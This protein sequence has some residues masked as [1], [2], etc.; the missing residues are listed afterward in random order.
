[1]KKEYNYN[2]HT[3]TYRCG[4][5]AFELEEEYINKYIE[6]GFKIVGFSDHMP[7]PLEEFPQEN[8]RMYIKDSSKYISKLSKLKNHYKDIEILISFECEYDKLY[9]KH[10]IKLKENSDYLILGQ[11]FIKN[12]NP[13]GNVDYPM[14]Y[15]NRVCEALDTGLFSYIAHPDLYLKYRDSIEISDYDKYINNCKKAAEIICKKA[16]KLNIP[17]EINLTFKNNIKIMKDNNYP[18]PHRLFFDIAKKF[19]NSFVLGID[20]HSKNVIDKYDDSSTSILKYLDIDKNVVLNYNPLLY[21]NDIMNKKYKA[22]KKNVKSYEYE[23][24]KSL[25]KNIKYND[26]YAIISLI[27]KDIDL[28][29]KKYIKLISIIKKEIDDLTN[30][31]MDINLKEKKIL[32]KKKYIKYCS[33]SY[34][35]RLKMLNKIYKKLNNYKYDNKIIKNILNYYSKDK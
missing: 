11:H 21:K 31:I 16:K 9:N 33:E 27:K 12:I 35:H 24:I 30:T 4:H 32:R 34:K 6:N 25:S 28:T 29:N 10:L 2:F 14:I 22:F 19:D 5:A 8:S 13:I 26:E 7:L 17:L 20:A 15:A 23:Y 1:M 3:H 18:Y